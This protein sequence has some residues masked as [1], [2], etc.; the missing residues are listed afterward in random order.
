MPDQTITSPDFVQFLREDLK[1]GIVKVKFVKKNGE[2]RVMKC[3]WDMNHIP[4]IH[5]PTQKE[6]REKNNELFVVYDVEKEGWRSFHI[7]SVIEATIT[8][9]NPKENS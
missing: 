6:P 9:P 8:I 5:H 4:E 1:H 2:T 7:D 3:T